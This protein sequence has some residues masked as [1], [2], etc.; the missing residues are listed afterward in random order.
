MNN[1]NKLLQHFGI[2]PLNRDTHII[3]S[4]NKR[5]KFRNYKKSHYEVNNKKKTSTNIIDNN[6]VKYTYIITSRNTIII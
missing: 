1:M 3:V 6:S 4:D 2:F 5:K